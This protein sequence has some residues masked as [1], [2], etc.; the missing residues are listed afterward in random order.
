[1]EW[2]SRVTDFAHHTFQ[3]FGTLTILTLQK[4]KLRH[5]LCDLREEVG[6]EPGIPTHSTS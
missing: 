4:K 3:E 6:F 1:M 5:G 2:F